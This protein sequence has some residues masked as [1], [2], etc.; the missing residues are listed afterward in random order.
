V[1]LFGP[2]G[3]ILHADAAMPVSTDHPTDQVLTTKAWIQA[4]V[5]QIVCR[6]LAMNQ[7]DGHYY[8]QCSLVVKEEKNDDKDSKS[9]R[10]TKKK[11]RSAEDV[12]LV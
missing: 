4:A 6:Q 2:I 8:H 1:I 3:P 5:L 7:F 11:T 12:N 9:L 10:I